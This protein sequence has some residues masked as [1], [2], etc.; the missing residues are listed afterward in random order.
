MYS[1]IP[2]NSLLDN[3]FHKYNRKKLDFNLIIDSD[4]C[5]IQCIWM[6]MICIMVSKNYQLSPS[7][8]HETFKTF[9]YKKS[10]VEKCCK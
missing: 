3:Q 4:L 9:Q 2:V 8:Y 6:D 10:R 5:N 7:L 1:R